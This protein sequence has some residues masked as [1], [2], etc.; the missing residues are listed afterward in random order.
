MSLQSHLARLKEQLRRNPA[1]PAPAL[2][3]ETPEQLH[4]FKD[5]LRAFDQARLELKLA[6][7]QQIQN[8]NTA[9]IVDRSTARRVIRYEQYV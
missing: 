7:P 5:E 6:T 3:A 1:M 9:V 2:R 8:E 4:D